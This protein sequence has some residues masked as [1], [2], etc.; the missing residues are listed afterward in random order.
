[1]PVVALGSRFAT[2]LPLKAA[3]IAAACVFLLLGAWA[4][5]FGIGG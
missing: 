4:A 2:K 1:M 3:R 5:V